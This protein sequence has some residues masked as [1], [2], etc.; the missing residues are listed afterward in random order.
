MRKII[1]L[2]LAAAV[3]L[4]VFSG[5]QETPEEPIVV[6]KDFDKL[7]EKAQMEEPPAPSVP[8]RESLGAP[9]TLT[10]TIQNN[11]GNLKVVVDATVTVPDTDRLPMLRVGHYSFSREDIRRF[12]DVLFQGAAPLDPDSMEPTRAQIQGQIGWLMEMRES[13]ELDDM[14]YDSVEQV[15]AAIAELMTKLETAPDTLDV[16]EHN[17]QQEY[18]YT[19]RATEDFVITSDLFCQEQQIEYCKNLN[20]YAAM[21]EVLSGVPN[22]SPSLQVKAELTEETG[23]APDEAYALAVDT[24]D[25]LGIRDMACNGRRAYFFTEAG[26]GVYE[27]MFTRMVNNVPITFTNDSGNEFDP[28]SVHAPWAY[29]MVRLFIDETGVCYMVYTSP[30]TVGEIL[31]DQVNMLPFAEIRQ[32]AE[33]MLPV[34]N[35][36]YRD[37]ETAINI[38]SVQLG[39]MRIVEEGYSDSGLLIPVWDFMGTSSEQDSGGKTYERGDPYSSYLTIN[40]IDGSI[41]DRTLGY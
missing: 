12:T 30:Y 19:L 34:V 35:D 24:V 38:H 16:V 37:N 10:M 36:Q 28:N 15:D 29:E 32:I 9:E 21:T 4:G 18:P 22:S 1:C 23:Y 40:A 3:M 26:F 7:K 20:R 17:F 41:I 31:S 25:K 33:R 27:F 2:C 5:C 13:G 11:E 39:L 14:K 6:Q 8:L